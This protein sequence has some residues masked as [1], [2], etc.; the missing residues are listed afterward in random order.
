L[1]NGY[2]YNVSSLPAFVVVQI[3]M[4]QTYW[5]EKVTDTTKRGKTWKC[6]FLV[7]YYR[8]EIID[9]NYAFMYKNLFK[10]IKDWYLLSFAI[11][12]K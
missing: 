11:A 9:T 12:L 1:A 7:L 5:L 6:L 4:T 3:N 2:R 10:M 8:V